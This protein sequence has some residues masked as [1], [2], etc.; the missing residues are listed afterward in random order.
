MKKIY[1]FLAAVAIASTT[2]AQT[3]LPR[4]LYTLDFEGITKPEDIKAE[5][6]GKGLFLQS[7]I[8]S[9]GTYYQNNPDVEAGSHKNYLIVPTQGFK[10]SNEKSQTEFSIGMWINAY[11]AN[12]SS[13]NHYYSTVLSAYSST[14][15]YKNFSWPMFSARE[16]QTLQINCAGWSDYTPEENVNG[17]N[18]EST[19]WNLIKM[20]DS[21][22]KDEEGNVITEDKGFDDNWHYLVFT[23][24]GINAKY[25]VDGVVKNEWNATNNNYC[26]PSAM[27]V[28]N[29]LYL[30]D[31]GPF[32]QDQ[33]GAY[34]YDDINFYSSVL[35]Q[36]QQEL[37]MNIKFGNIGDEERFVIA[38]NQI[39]TEM[40]EEQRYAGEIIELGFSTLAEQ[41]DNYIASIDLSELTT[42]ESINALSSEIKAKHE[43]IAEVVNAYKEAYAKFMYYTE[44]KNNTMY[45]G[46]SQ[47]GTV[48]EASL[49][50][51]NNATTVDVIKSAVSTAE[52][53][54]MAYLF[55]QDIPENGA[56]EVTRAIDNPWFCDEA[57]EPTV[58]ENGIAAYPVENPATQKGAW[59]NFTSENLL[60]STDCTMYYTQGRT[61]WNSFH[62]S[63]AANGILDIH[64]TISGLPAG[65]YIVKADMVSSADATNN[66]IYATSNDVTKVSKTFQ[67]NGWDGIS[68]GVGAWETLTTDKVRVGE[69]GILTI[70]ATA[71]TEGI[72]YKGWYCVTNFRLFYTGTTADLDADLAEKEQ[73][74]TSASG[75]IKYEGNK[76]LVNNKF[77]AIKTSED[78]TYTKISKLTDLIAE[79]NT[80]TAKENSFNTI[81]SLE[82]LR[83][84]SEGEVKDVY[85]HAI[86]EINKSIENGA[87]AYD[88]DA[89]NAL[90]GAYTSYA[91]T[92]KATI[93]WGTASATNEAKSQVSALAAETEETLAEKKVSL[94]SIMKSS[95]SEFSASEAEPKDITGVIA[96]PSFDNDSYAGWTIAKGTSGN[97]YAECEFFN[98]NFDIFQTVEGLPAGTYRVTVQGYYRDGGREESVNNYGT[99]ITEEDETTHNL[100]T[101]NA[102]LYANNVTSVMMS[103][104]ADS[105]VGD[106]NIISANWYQPHPEYE[107]NESVSYPDDMNSA[108]H[109]FNNGK[110][111]NNQ[112]TVYLSE[113]GDLTFGIKKEKTIANDWTIFDNFKLLYL[114]QEAP[115]AI[116]NANSTVAS[117]SAIYS[118]SGV[119]S[120][121]Y[122]KGINI[123]RMSDGTVV[124][125]FV[126]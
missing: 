95:I 117:P 6:V 121:T 17:A 68:E 2:N 114:G 40:E 63:T 49:N 16:R 60:G 92:I 69:D 100:F 123:I 120:N 96:N 24:N 101:A 122:S 48:L 66:H 34:A 125:K 108:N 124:K 47:F 11:V 54:K 13:V 107:P 4:A 79:I 25:Y 30:G 126:K 5:Q 89:L 64:Q 23:F 35:T 36:E 28:L 32:W 21:E 113:A 27:A 18:A 37:I 31:C 44:V 102:V 110:Y 97:Y 14:D 83:K 33:D 80:I 7:S 39:A 99:I 106:E 3:T 109:C 84:N 58:N 61:T 86:S 81:A 67:G 90:G 98:Q 9:F 65:Y 74:V 94:I 53:A 75:N 15:S 111:A 70:G 88:F 104:G 56:I 42:M 71:T 62:S 59:E 50:A 118:I 46:A 10:E 8:P 38:Q 103:L 29:N 19:E 87:T 1:T 57:I 55:S 52:E 22:N 105:I 76:T 78:D 43:A 93:E 119:R 112:V 45:A 26:F 115:T 116:E 20:Y 82:D 72:A 77:N 51:I 85:N 41:L 12:K 91:A 73:E